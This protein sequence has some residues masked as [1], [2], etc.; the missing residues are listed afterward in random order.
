MLVCKLRPWYPHGAAVGA[1]NLQPSTHDRGPRS[2]SH[3]AG[4]EIPTTQSR[5]D[6]ISQA[7][8]QACLGL[9]LFGVWSI[10]ANLI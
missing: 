5:F 1:W 4:A 9:V 10:Y 6:D 2:L 3:H 7:V 8:L